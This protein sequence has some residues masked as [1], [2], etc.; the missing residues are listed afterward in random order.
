MTTTVSFNRPKILG[1]VNITRDS[2]SDGGLYLNSDKA[3]EHALSLLQD[4]AD[5]VDLGP[6]SSNPDAETVNAAEEIARLRP[7]IDALK[8]QNS[9][10]SIDSFQPETQKY[11]LER[12]VDYINDIQGFPYPDLYPELAQ[13]RAKLILMHSVQRIGKATRLNVEPEG[14]V[15]TIIAFFSERVQALT[16]AG[17]DRDR[18]IMDPGMGFFLS[19]NPLASTMVIRNLSTL[20]KALQLPLLV[21]VSR[22]SFLRK[23]T[24]RE[25]DEAGAATL[26][27]ELASVLYG[28]DYIRTHDTKALN[29]ALSVFESLTRSV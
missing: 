13:S 16:A 25:T 11:A 24:G 15:Q 14:I 19:S 20:K 12:D 22:K 1:I 4:G 3:I 8:Q 21:S 18:I 5:I 2:F 23:I 6:A 7:V 17:I 27:A 9:V 10:I 28:A 29:D 26:A